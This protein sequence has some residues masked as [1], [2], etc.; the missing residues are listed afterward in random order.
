[1]IFKV[2]KGIDSA[3]CTSC[4]YNA[5]LFFLDYPPHDLTTAG[6]TNWIFVIGQLNVITPS[7]KSAL[8]AVIQATTEQYGVIVSDSTPGFFDMG[9]LLAPIPPEDPPN[10]GISKLISGADAAACAAMLLDCGL[11]S[12]NQ[13]VGSN[14]RIT[15]QL[16]LSATNADQSGAFD[17]VVRAFAATFTN[18]QVS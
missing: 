17:S 12:S 7:Q 8:D 6:F 1:M 5:G 3:K 11:S 9:T 16:R 10:A 4:L 2:L 15:S 13:A 18:A 14:V